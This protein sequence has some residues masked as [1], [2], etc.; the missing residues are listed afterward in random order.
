MDKA[1]GQI[2]SKLPE[3]IQT[4]LKDI[5]VENLQEIR[6]R[7]GRKTYLYYTDKINSVDFVPEASDLESTLSYFCASSVYAYGNNIKNGFVTLPGGHRAGIVGRAVYKEEKVANIVNLTGINIR[8][9]RECKGCSDC[10]INKIYKEEKILNTL[11]ISEPNG[12]KTTLLRDIARHLGEHHKVVIVD[13]RSEIAAV[14]SSMPQFDVGE[15]TDV[16]DGFLKHDGIV[17]ALRS[18]SPDV[19]ITDEIGTEDDV[20]AIKNILKG[21]AKIITSIHAENFCDVKEKKKELISLFDLAIVLQKR[22]VTECINL[23][24]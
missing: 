18:L 3:N 11:V 1:L 16:L 15:H 21:G 6:L 22:E 7:T 5:D 23:Q 17:L 10:V 9:A 8:I 20:T 2:I 24:E 14:K 19:I 12:G 13:E 4:V